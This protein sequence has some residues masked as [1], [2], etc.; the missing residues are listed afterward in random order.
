MTPLASSTGLLTGIV[1]AAVL[2]ISGLGLS[3]ALGLPRA[4]PQL[5]WIEFGFIIF[6]LSAGLAL[7][8]GLLLAWLG[9]FSIGVLILLL[10]LVALVSWIVAWRRGNLQSMLRSVSRPARAEAALIGL[11]A[12]LS[13][14]YFRPHEFIEGGA[15]AGV[16][17]NMGAHIA[18]TGQL[19]VNDPLI[20][21][22]DSS[23]YPVF[24]RE[25]PA[26]YLTRYYYL[27]G[28]F[29]S[30]T[31]PGQII[32]QFYA[33]QAVSIA[34]LTAIGGVPLGLL[35]TPLWG[36]AGVAAVYFLARSLFDR[37]AALLGDA[38]LAEAVREGWVTPPILVAAG[39]P[40]RKPVMK[41]HDLLKDLESDREDR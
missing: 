12:L 15:D 19:L 40:P 23:Y 28:Y 34:I 29:V 20:A 2:I 16:Y 5:D 22:L 1:F 35:A 25:Q 27:P 4:H 11:L 31:V 13:V 18:Q 3:S 38:L 14:I 8:F 26:H 10:G 36:L 33:L 6:M 41:L 32:P 24:F 37:R 17:V 30:D 9:W 39:P 21:Q 7:W